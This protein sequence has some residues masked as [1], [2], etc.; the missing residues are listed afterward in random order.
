MNDLTYAQQ[1]AV[2]NAYNR[3]SPREQQTALSSRQG[4]FNFLKRQ[5][6]SAIVHKLVGLT[7]TVIG[8]MF[9]LDI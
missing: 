6:L 8:A 9:G 3:A 4:F 5:G 1:Q 7:F 2:R